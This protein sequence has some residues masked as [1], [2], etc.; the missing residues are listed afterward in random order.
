LQPPRLSSAQ[1]DWSEALAALTG[2][3]VLRVAALGASRR[4]PRLTRGVPPVIGRLNAVMSS[5]F[6][7]VAISPVPVL[8]PFDTDALMRDLAAGTAARDNQRYLSGF[9][10]AD[11]FYPG[12]SGY[13]A[14]FTVRTADVPELADIKFADPI[15]VMISGSAL[16]YELDDPTPA[17]GA[18]APALETD[19][20][21]IRR[22][23]HEHHLRYTFVRFGVP[24]VVSTTCFNAGV[25]RYRMPTC[26]AA[27]RV[28]T[29]LLR[30]LH[31]VGGT[32]QSPRY[33]QALPIERPR[34][35]SPTFAYYSP[36]RL[37]A[38]TGF[39]GQSGRTDYTVY[40]QIRFPMAEAPAYINSQ[41]F[42]SRNRPLTP[43]QTAPPNYS[44]PWRDNFC[45]RRGFPVGQCPAGIGHQGQDIRPP[46]CQPPPGSD[47]CTPRHDLVAVRDGAILRAPKQEAAYLVVNTETEHIRFRYLHMSPAKM[48]QDRVLS[49]RRVYEG[50][51]IGQVGNYSKREGGTSY[52]LHFDIQVPTRDGW[53]FVNPYMTLVASYERLIGGRGEE[54]ASDAAPMAVGPRT[55]PAT[56]GQGGKPI[57]LTMQEEKPIPSI[58]REEKSGPRKHAGKQRSGH[59]SK[60]H[61]R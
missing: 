17:H 39:G 23:L 14:V 33:V 7:G 49:G 22:L 46:R 47:R 4:V 5:R 54:I 59:K 3:E 9:Q 26:I 44:Y 56:L 19:F 13:D 31:I 51:V 8:L 6:P 30:A 61:R 12:P 35:K 42:Q 29:R 38:G 24:Y 55:F 1:V 57:G 37:L 2:I 27:D 15:P 32:P 18:P 11:F 45:E 50:E 40:T 21:G 43:D 48:D 52:H 10:P 53:V 36:G 34:Q 25:S 41:M 58:I 20:P 16:L 28:L 60:K